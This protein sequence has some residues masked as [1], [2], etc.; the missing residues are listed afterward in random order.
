MKSGCWNWTAG[1]SSNGYSQFYYGGKI[2]GK[3]HR[4]SYE[5]H[6][7]AIP[8]GMTIDHL[9]DNRKCVN[10]K[11]LKAASMRENVLRS[12]GITAINARKTHCVHGHPLN[13]D[14]LSIIKRSKHIERRCVQC[15]YARKRAWK[16]KNKEKTR[17]YH[18]KWYL[19]RRGILKNVKV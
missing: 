3:G 2:G 6:K 17:V 14:N 8:E 1:L 9:C 15:V 11:H 5:Y 19:Q 10:P 18:R 16:E 13:G 4:Y 7:G 12:R